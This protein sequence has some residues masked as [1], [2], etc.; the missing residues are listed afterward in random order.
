MD[1]GLTQH[2]LALRLGCCYQ[3]VARWEQDRSVPLP[4]RWPALEAVLGPG[5]PA[6][7]EDL[8]GRIRAARLR[9]GLTRA[10]LARQAGV[11]ERT[12]RNSERGMRAPRRETLRRLR[13]VVDG[14]GS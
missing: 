5:L 8:A 7:P 11:D 12:V 1:R 4:R 2:T 9:L 3:S 10:E 14:P 13:A 6:S